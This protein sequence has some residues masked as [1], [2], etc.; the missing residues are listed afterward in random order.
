VRSASL[1]HL[2]SH[3][4]KCGAPAACVRNGRGEGAGLR[5]AR[6]PRAVG[7]ATAAAIE[8]AMKMAVRIRDRAIRRAGEL[9]KQIEP[10]TGKN[11]QY[12]QVKGADAQPFPLGSR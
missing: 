8:E 3:G 7:A 6:T 9:L 12:A 11:N 5:R 1:L 2:A 10:A 4:R